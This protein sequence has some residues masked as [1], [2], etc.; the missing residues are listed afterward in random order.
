MFLVLFS[1][2]MAM[3]P[4]KNL[5]VSETRMDKEEKWES[6]KARMGWLVNMGTPRSISLLECP[7]YP[8]GCFCAGVQD[9]PVG[10]QSSASGSGVT[11]PSLEAAQWSL[12]AWPS[13][14]RVRWW[15]FL[16]RTSSAP[17][18]S[19]VCLARAVI[20]LKTAS[21]REHQFTKIWGPWLWI[22][23]RLRT[24][25]RGSSSVQSCLQI[26]DCISV[27]EPSNLRQ[28]TSATSFL[29]KKLFVM[30]TNV[31]EMCE[32]QK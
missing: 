29:K 2:I 22:H 21:F 8:P 11:C 24:V 13:L 25:F 15:D 31:T 27:Q 19:L 7:S 5:M 16:S 26:P 17:H 14:S 23:Y 30:G 18:S 4:Q 3:F 32:K 20:Y 9:F 28:A 1:L 10:Q 6:E 12:S